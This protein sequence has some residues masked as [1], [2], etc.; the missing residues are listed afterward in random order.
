MDWIRTA[1]LRQ[2]VI[3]ETVRMRGGVRLA[4]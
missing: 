1:A 2:A 3:A 4:A